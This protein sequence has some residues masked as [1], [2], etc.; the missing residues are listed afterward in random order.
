MNVVDCHFTNQ[1]NGATCV[2]IYGKG[3]HPSLKNILV[4][5]SGTRMRQKQMS[6]ID[7]F[8]E[9]MAFLLEKKAKLNLMVVRL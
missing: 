6:S 5:D 2:N 8:Q 1:M 9:N 7:L 4:F 3:T